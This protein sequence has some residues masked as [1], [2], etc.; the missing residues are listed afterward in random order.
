M[1]TRHNSWNSSPQHTHTHKKK[2]DPHAHSAQNKNKLKLD[3]SVHNIVLTCPRAASV[4]G[5]EKTLA[6]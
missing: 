4:R 2:K 3:R 6:R 1:D 5:K